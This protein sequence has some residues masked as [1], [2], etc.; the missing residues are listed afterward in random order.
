MTA[1]Q[2]GPEL[3]ISPETPSSVSVLFAATVQYELRGRK[4]STVKQ[5]TDTASYAS[6]FALQQVSAK[7]GTAKGCSPQGRRGRKGIPGGGTG[8]WTHGV[9]ILEAWN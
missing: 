3:D 2:S 8:R 5:N 6:V 1:E 7:P 4:K 9:T